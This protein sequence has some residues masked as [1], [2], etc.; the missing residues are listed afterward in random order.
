MAFYGSSAS[1]LMNSYG[2]SGESLGESRGGYNLDNWRSPGLQSGADSEIHQKLDN[3][4][5]T[6]KERHVTEILFL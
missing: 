1:N 4:R 3:L 6:W 2:R 5:I